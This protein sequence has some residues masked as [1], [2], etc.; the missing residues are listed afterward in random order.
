[1]KTEPVQRSVLGLKQNLRQFIILILVNA[2]VGAMIGIE[3]SIFPEFAAFKFNI[4]AT[5]VILSFIVIF[6][7]SKAIANYFSGFLA[8]KYTRKKV[9]LLGWILALPVPL[10][11]I[12]APTWNWIIFANV[13]LGI[14]Q[15]FAWSS[16]VVMK[17]DLVG[18]QNRGLAMGLNEFAGYIAVA[19]M[20]FFTAY[21]AD[22][23]GIYPFPFYLGLAVAVL[24]LLIS[25]IFV[26]DT[27]GFVQLE[28][29]TTSS[30]IPRLKNIFLETSF[31]NK[32]LSAVTQAG[33]V[34]NLNDGMVWG[35]L[36]IILIQKNFALIDIGII[37]SIYPA[38]WGLT[39][40]V[41]GKLADMVAKKQLLFWGMLLQAFAIAYLIFAVT[42]VEMVTVA[43]FLGLGTAMVY[44]TFLA[45]ISDNTHAMDRAKSLGIFRFWRDSGYAIGA[46]ITGLTA[47]YFGAPISIGIIAA[48]TFFSAI[49]IKIRMH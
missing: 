26:K 17:I 39:Q 35:L 44:P 31:T 33:L 13:L 16:T 25:W 45:T 9:L 10:I 43:V 6:G 47:D 2:F 3:R 14:H 30:S 41:T 19:L 49:F 8:A 29:E 23:Y 18:Q 15:G 42:Y 28:S 32:N 4:H 34:N 24:G 21:I 36:P 12:Y 11:F 37:T 22:Q 5:S 40:I 1:M 27:S 7:F 48:L 46:I 20:A 38:V